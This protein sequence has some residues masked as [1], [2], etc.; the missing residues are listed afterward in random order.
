MNNFG[1]LIKSLNDIA[2]HY[3]AI[4]K[5]A[6]TTPEQEW[7]E[8][9]RTQPPSKP[10]YG[11]P[12]YIFVKIGF[13][14]DPKRF[15]SQFKILYQ[16]RSRTPELANYFFR[17]FPPGTK[18]SE[19]SFV[20]PDSYMTMGALAQRAVDVQIALEEA[21]D[22]PNNLTPE[23]RAS[24]V[25]YPDDT[26]RVPN[27]KERIAAS[28]EKKRLREMQE[29]ASDAGARPNDPATPP[30]VDL[31]KIEQ[32][33]RAKVSLWRTTG[34][35]LAAEFLEHFM[36]GDGVRRAFEREEYESLSH[37][38][39]A[40]ETNRRR[41]VTMFLG[42]FEGIPTLETVTR[43]NL[44]DQILSQGKDVFEDSW[45][46]AFKLTPDATSDFGS[47]AR[48]LGNALFHPDIAVST[49]SSSLW[50]KG[51]FVLH[52][53]GGVL[54]IEG[55]VRHMWNDVY[56]FKDGQIFNA[57]GFAMQEIGRAHV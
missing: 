31:D 42:K 45:E 19:I 10:P 23:Q 50:S 53:D 17:P 56:D 4:N 43:R 21:V 6:S 55:E 20:G 37:L 52:R 5:W 14:M 35:T 13:D 28:L 54:R 18:A 7:R 24:L 39:D 11:V 36:D 44:V 12:P 32:S 2:N 22:F 29:E 48:Q 41:F 3:D 34:L 26:A 9:T 30:G 16:Q 15:M 25:D 47:K 57:E 40:E 27:L 1:G 8:M 38:L 33:L 46:V 51:E 49:G